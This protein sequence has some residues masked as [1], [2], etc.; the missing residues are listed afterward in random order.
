MRERR[1]APRVRQNDEALI[2]A[3]STE[4]VCRVVSRSRTGLCLDVGGIIGIPDHFSVE[5]LRTGEVLRLRVRWR[6]DGQIGARLVP[7][8]RVTT[9]ASA[10]WISMR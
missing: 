8:A 2:L 5:I 7:E 1:R 6:G 3:A 10:A 4:L 9:K